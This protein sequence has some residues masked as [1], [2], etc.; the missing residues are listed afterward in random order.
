M[1]TVV[2]HSSGKT[3]AP[4]VDGTMKFVLAGVI[5]IRANR[6]EVAAE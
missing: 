5:H 1:A 3:G 6:R 2:L 4:T